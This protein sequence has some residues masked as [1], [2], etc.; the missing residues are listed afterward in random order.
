MTAAGP[1]RWSVGVVALHWIGAALILEL[2]GHGWLMVHGGLSAGTTFDLFQW[3]KT[4]G[5]L[6]LAVTLA[7]LCAR[8]ATHAPPAVPIAWERRLAASVQ[9]LLYAA[10][11]VMIASGWLTV[12]ASPLPIPTEVLGL[13]IPNIA[14]PDAALFGAA[15]VVHAAAAWTIAGLVALHVAGALKHAWIDRDGV[16]ARMWR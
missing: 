9:A 16:M 6:A 11:L 10:T 8:I 1:G 2:L 3:H 12:S 14:L 4:V 5:F 15:K 7:R 13:T